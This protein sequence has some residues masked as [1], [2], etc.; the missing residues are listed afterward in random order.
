MLLVLIAV[1]LAVPTVL[2]LLIALAN[3]TLLDKVH[4]L[5]ACAVAAAMLGPVLL[6]PRRDIQVHGLRPDDHRLWRNDDRL[7]I[8]HRRSR[9]VADVD[10]AVDPGLVDADGDADT[11]FAEGAGRQQTADGEDYKVLVPARVKVVVASFTQPAAV[12]G[13]PSRVPLQPSRAQG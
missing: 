3:P 13:L 4:G 2:L 9:I 1:I 6:V 12:Y 11:G 7:A 10:S 8:D 5:P